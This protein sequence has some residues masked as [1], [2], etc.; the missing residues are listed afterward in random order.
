MTTPP[1]LA[2]TFVARTFRPLSSGLPTAT[3]QTPIKYSS[4]AADRLPLKR[5][6]AISLSHSGN[7]A[8]RLGLLALALAVFS[9]CQSIDMNSPQLR[10]IDASP[11][12]GVL[13]SYQ[14]NAGLAYNLSFGTMTSYVPMSAGSYTLTADR[15]G[16]R[17]TLATTNATLSP[18]KQYTAIIGN[19]LAS[20]Q[21]TIL[22]DQSQPAPAGEIAVRF[23]QQATRSGAVDIYLVP[24]NGRPANTQAIAT[25]LSFGAN[26]GYL[27]VP[28]GTYAIDIVPTGTVLVSSTVTLLSGAQ[29]DYPSGSVRTV[30]LID[31]EILGPQRAGLTPGVQTITLADADAL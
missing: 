23:V 8:T 3:I 7:R 1:R 22:L 25:N 30:V 15:A 14:N 19:D 12:A 16:T 5:P 27:S 18:G 28:A 29:V 21:Q 20:M 24:R 6:V 2:L 31:Q 13:D 11:D 17:Q 26:S 9:G 10:V 4:R